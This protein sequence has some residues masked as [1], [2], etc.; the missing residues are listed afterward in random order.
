MVPFVSVF[1]SVSDK[2]MKKSGVHH[3][4]L[5]AKKTKKTKKF[6]QKIASFRHP[7]L[8]KFLMFIS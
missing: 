8:E 5:L 1:S 7:K 2:E 3:I 4:D 6:F